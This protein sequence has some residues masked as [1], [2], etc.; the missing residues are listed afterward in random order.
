VIVDVHTHLFPAAV[1]D[2]RAR[3]LAA[4]PT[5]RALY[6]EPRARLATA[7]DLLA[8]MDAAGVD[9]SVALGFA[10]SDDATCR[11][12]N[13]YLL[14]AA[15]ASGGRIVPFC[16]VNLGGTPDAIAREIERV[17]AGGARGLGELRPASQG[18]DLAASDQ[19]EALGDAAAAHDLAL[20]FHVSEPV[21]HRYAGKEGLPVAD[22]LAFVTRHPGQRCVAAHLG[23]GLPFYAQM[24]EVERALASTAFDTAAA[25]LLYGA[26][27]YR[28]VID[29]VGGDRLLFGSDFPLLSQQSALAKLRAA[30]P[31]A[32][33]AARVLGDN[34]RNLLEPGPA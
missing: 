10:W 30:L 20:L 18:C 29:L 1:I 3:Y 8:S 9:R 26:E 25:S 19:A 21:G 11:R 32:G 5:F 2:E 12:H 14:E 24:P 6:T 27:V 17:T 23:G 22:Y 33:L 34:A 28:H 13:D 15:A 16:T 31:D 4:D 7:A